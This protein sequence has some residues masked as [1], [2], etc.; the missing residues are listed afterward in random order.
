MGGRG[1]AATLQGRTYPCLAT[2]RCQ[3]QSHS[4][5]GC[6]GH[7]KTSWQ[8]GMRSQCDRAWSQR[9]GMGPSLL[10]RQASSLTSWKTGQSLCS[11]FPA[12]RLPPD[13]LICFRLLRTSSL[14]LGRATPHSPEPSPSLRTSVDWSSSPPAWATN[15]GPLLPRVP[16]SVA[17][18]SLEVQRVMLPGLT[19]RNREESSLSAGMDS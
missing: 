12:P 2:A 19:L 3:V 9:E 5:G 6:A 11:C 15:K 14:S 10:E 17:S 8:P 7:Q 13:Q 4:P 18:C 1:W 16:F